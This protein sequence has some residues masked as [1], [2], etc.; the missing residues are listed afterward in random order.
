MA[1]AARGPPGATTLLDL[2]AASRAYVDRIGAAAAHAY[3]L[4]PG[5]DTHLDG[6]GSVVFGRMVAD[7][8]LAS[9]AGRCL[10]PWIRPNA[11][12]SQAIRDGMPA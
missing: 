12:L 7:L 10:G 5:D 8:L 11:T 2:N 9:G 3:N 6:W 1:A 4:Q